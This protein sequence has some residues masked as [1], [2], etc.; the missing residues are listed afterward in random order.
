MR[1]PRTQHVRTIEIRSEHLRVG[2]PTKSRKQNIIM[3][4]KISQLFFF[5]LKEDISQSHAIIMNGPHLAG[6]VRIYR[7]V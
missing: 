4:M 7:S 1:K 3:P 6:A 2:V 5:S